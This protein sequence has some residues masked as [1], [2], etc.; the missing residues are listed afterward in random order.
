VVP[1]AVHKAGFHPTAIFGVMGAAAGVGA[2]LDLNRKQIVDALGIAGSMASGIIEYLA[3]GAWTKRL[4]PGWAAQSGIRAALLARGGFVGPRTV[5]EGVH[6]LF[7]GFAHTAK[8]HYEALDDFGRSWVLETL[9]FKPYPC[10]TMAHPYIDCARRLAARGIKPT[11]V[12]ELVCEVAEGTVH[13]LW[14]PLPAKQRPP[15]GYAAKFAT[16]FLLATGF[17]HDG[18][19]LD[20]FTDKAVNDPVVLALAAKVHYVVRTSH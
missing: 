8:G 3:E 4:H 13:R 17:V 11:D 6:G 2:A 14:D 16:P 5:F 1:K 18:V 19:G 10:G 7:Q 12:K 15:N 20:A 9:A